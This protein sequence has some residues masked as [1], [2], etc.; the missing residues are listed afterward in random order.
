MTASQRLPIVSGDTSQPLRLVFNATGRLHDSI[1]PEKRLQQVQSTA[2]V[3]R[4]D[5]RSR[6]ASARESY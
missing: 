6:T 2:L 5:Q 1:Q 3:G 4:S